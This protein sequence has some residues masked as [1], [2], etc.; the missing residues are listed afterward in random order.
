MNGSPN[1]NTNWVTIEDFK[2]LCFDLA[3]ELLGRFEPIPPFEKA[4]L[5]RLESSL[6]TPQQTFGGILLYPT[7][8]KQAA[9]L[10]YFLVKNHPFENGNKRIA[11]TTLLMFLTMNKKWLKTTSYNLYLLAIDVAQSNSKAKDAVLRDL[12]KFINQSL[13]D[14]PITSK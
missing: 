10:F 11:L 1:S 13:I 9:A 6:K 5:G 14:F 7:L 12:E 4:A 3:K 2:L 8:V